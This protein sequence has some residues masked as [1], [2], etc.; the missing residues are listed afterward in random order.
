MVYR[1]P[2][3]E[4]WTEFSAGKRRPAIAD[5]KGSGRFRESFRRAR[6]KIALDA[7]IVDRFEKTTRCI[8]LFRVPNPITDSIVEVIAEL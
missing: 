1:S 6:L 3:G 5:L 7:R 8:H 2:A 4:N